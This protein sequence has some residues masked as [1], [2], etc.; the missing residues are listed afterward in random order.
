MD[1]H[2]GRLEHGYRRSVRVRHSTPHQN[3][4][5]N[6]VLLSRPK[7]YMKESKYRE[8]ILESKKKAFVGELPDEI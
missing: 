8:K 1:I 3:R 4:P 6:D 2:I 7:G 5:S